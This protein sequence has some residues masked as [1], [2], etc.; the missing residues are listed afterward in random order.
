MMTTKKSNI[1]SSLDIPKSL[2]YHF[3]LTYRMVHLNLIL[4]QTFEKTKNLQKLKK[5]IAI[6]YILL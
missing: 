4:S 1:S 2:I 5:R 3:L 6:Q